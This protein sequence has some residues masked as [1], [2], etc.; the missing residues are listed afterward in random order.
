MAIALERRI[1]RHLRELRQIP[2]DDLLERRYAKLRRV[3]VVV[4]A[5]AGPS[6]AGP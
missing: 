6:S 2:M 1:G 5:A 3:G 4:E